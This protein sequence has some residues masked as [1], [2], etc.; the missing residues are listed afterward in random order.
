[1]DL[2]ACGL[3]LEIM[4]EQKDSPDT[5]YSG[6]SAVKNFAGTNK[7]IQLAVGA[8]GA[9]KLLPK[10][11][12]IYVERDPSLAL[13]IIEGINVLLDD[14]ETNIRDVMVSECYT[15]VLQLVKQSY[16]R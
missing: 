11:L 9:N 4:E 2:G 10:L 5:Q 3:V 15:N 16:F 12:T 1:M 8:M 14:A 7:E 13:H 6:V